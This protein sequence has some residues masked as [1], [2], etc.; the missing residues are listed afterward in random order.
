MPLVDGLRERKKHETRRELMYTA[1]RLFTEHGYDSVNVE[2]I[3]AEANVSTRTFFRYFPSKAAACFGFVNTEIEELRA[4]DD[5]LTTTEEQIRDYAARVAADAE[6]YATQWRLALEHPQ[7]RAHR[8]EILFEFDDLLAEAFMRETPGVDPATARLAAYLPTHLIPAT[9]EAWV[10]G[11]A[12]L[13]PPS[14]EPQLA[15]MRKAVESLL[16]R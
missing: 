12:K 7:V 11:G 6:F 3:A 4:S 5:T 1:L 13:P 10:L 16:G 14:F 8:L 2:Q 15:E 9:M